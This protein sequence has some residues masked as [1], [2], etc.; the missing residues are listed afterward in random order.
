MDATASTRLTF[1]LAEPDLAILAALVRRLEDRPDR[2]I[3]R[4][5]PELISTADAV[6]YALRTTARVLHLDVPAGAG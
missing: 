6:R 4:Y 1:R 3:T 5:G 2:R